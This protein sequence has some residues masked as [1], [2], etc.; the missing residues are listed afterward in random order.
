MRLTGLLSALFLVMAT[1]TA[2]A[3]DVPIAAFYGTWQGAGVAENA[4]SLYF[5]MTTRDFNVVVV[6]AGEGFTVT[7]TTIIHSGGDPNNPDIRRREATLTFEPAERTGV[8]EAT[9]SGNP[10]D[11]EVLSWARI[12]ENTLSVYQM[13]LNESGGFELTSYDR[14]LT[15]L[16]MELHFRRLRDGEQVRT[17]TGRLIKISG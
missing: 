1:L 14:T 13:T 11:G 3:A 16:G 9:N 7:W 4:D 15:G 17:V 10:V 12:D 2:R 6:P 8:F 5:A